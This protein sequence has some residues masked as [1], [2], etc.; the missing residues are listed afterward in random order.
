MN[1]NPDMSVAAHIE[2]IQEMMDARMRREVDVR[3]WE[4][5]SAHSRHPLRMIP[6]QCAVVQNHLSLTLQG[7]ICRTNSEQYDRLTGDGY[8]LNFM[9]EQYEKGGEQ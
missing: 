6:L 1:Y 2:K 4:I 7:L 3:A 8:R 5:A 9:T